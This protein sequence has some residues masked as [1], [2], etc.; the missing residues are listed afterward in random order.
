MI[1]MQ[2]QYKV[3]NIKCGGCA[4]TVV[5]ALKGRFP[6]ISVNL[7]DEPRIVSATID[8]KEDEEYL[9]DTLRKYGYPLETEELSAMNKKYLS[10]KSYLS[11]MHGK[12]IAKTKP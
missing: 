7:D 2:K 10:G 4:S 1:N 5:D 6:D 12:I 3:M 8:S 9:I 11:C